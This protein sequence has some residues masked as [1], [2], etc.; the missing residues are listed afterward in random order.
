MPRKIEHTNDSVRRV[1]SLVGAGAMAVSVFGGAS[2][3]A[4]AATG[5]RTLDFTY[6]NLTVFEDDEPYSWWDTRETFNYANWPDLHLAQ[7]GPAATLVDHRCVGGE[8]RSELTMSASRPTS[9]P[10]GT[11]RATV[12]LKLYEGTSCSTQDLEDQRTVVVDVAPGQSRNVSISLEND[13]WGGG[14]WAY[15]DRLTFQND[16]G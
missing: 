4:D 2:G 15:L 8:V 11:I 10:S 3:T 9:L 13:E 6:G 16:A 1:L 12:T 5:L 14:D 7:G